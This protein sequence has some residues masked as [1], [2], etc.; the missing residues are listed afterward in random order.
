MIVTTFPVALK[1]D[2]DRKKCNL[3]FLGRVEFGMKSHLS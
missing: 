3:G 2:T 1:M